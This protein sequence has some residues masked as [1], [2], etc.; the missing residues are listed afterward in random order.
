MIEHA[1]GWT[2]TDL[3]GRILVEPYWSTMTSG[4]TVAEED[5]QGVHA[6]F[7]E[8]PP[9]AFVLLLPVQVALAAEFRVASTVVLSPVQVALAA[10]CPI[11][12][13]AA[14]AWR[15]AW[16]RLLGE[17]GHIVKCKWLYGVPKCWSR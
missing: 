11:A 10:G 7:W 1:E 8:A 3:R 2:S 13:A 17:H 12:L 16:I 9:Q 6:Y 5:M 4:V 15:V 14:E